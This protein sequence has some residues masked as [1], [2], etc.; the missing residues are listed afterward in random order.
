MIY[1]HF[2]IMN[3]NLKTRSL[4]TAKNIHK[5]K[6]VNNKYTNQ[7]VRQ[8]ITIAKIAQQPNKPLN[9]NTS[10]YCLTVFLLIRNSELIY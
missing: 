3:F 1:V 6:I 8:K 5:N 9:N 4:Q 7:I 10:Y 2:I